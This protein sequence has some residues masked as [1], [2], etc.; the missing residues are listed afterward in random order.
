MTKKKNRKNPEVK[1]NTL[2]DWFKRWGLLILAILGALLVA[3]TW[4]LPTRKDK[5]K[6]FQEAKEGAASLKEK[7][8]DELK[9]HELKMATRE[10]EL[11]EIKEIEDEDSRLRE[12]ARF[13]NRR[14]RK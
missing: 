3:L 6:I 4:I 1:A 8:A 5:P 2:W 11:E 12:L 9:T 14:T 10:K 13:A 7:A